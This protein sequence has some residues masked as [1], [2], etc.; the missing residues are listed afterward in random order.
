MCKTNLQIDLPGLG[1]APAAAMSGS[2]RL[3]L[4]AWNG[5]SGTAPAGHAPACA[6]ASS[7]QSAADV[8][9]APHVLVN[10]TAGDLVRQLHA[11]GLIYTTRCP[12]RF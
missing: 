2:P 3:P 6:S 11:E 9:P 1:A 4:G 7:A 12:R 10:E 5:A 8:P